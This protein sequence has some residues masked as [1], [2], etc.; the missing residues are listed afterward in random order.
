MICS[1]LSFK[2]SHETEPVEILR[3]FHVEAEVGDA[4]E[5]L[6]GGRSHVCRV[7]RVATTSNNVATVRVVEHV[8]VDTP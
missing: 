2:L 3:D 5:L 7:A 8:E 6:H 1:L 4:V